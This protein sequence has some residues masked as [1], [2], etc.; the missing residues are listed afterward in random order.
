MS[1]VS[2]ANKVSP[3]R[4]SGSPVPP[5]IYHACRILLG[6]IFIIASIDKIERPWDFG[7][8]IY[9]YEILKGAFAYFISPMAAVLPLVEFVSG[10]LILINRWVRPAALLILALNVVFMLA[11][12]SVMARGMDI[13]CGC[14]LDVGPIA[15]IAGTQA[16][17][18]SLLRDFAIIAMN[19]VVLFAPQSRGR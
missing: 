10:I 7:R 6:A 13:E 1:E 11:I 2:G 17:A 12:A 16:D 15:A 14:G 9:S 18:G 8:A 5:V 4:S 3:E 19:L